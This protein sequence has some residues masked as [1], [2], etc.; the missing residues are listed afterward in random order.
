MLKERIL[1]Q[2]TNLFSIHGIKNVSMDDLASSLGISK[3][4]IYENFKNKEDVLKHCILVAR[5]KRRSMME[6]VISQS[7]NI[8]DGCLHLIHNNKFIRLPASVFWDDIFKYYPE[9][10]QTILEDAAQ[11][12]DYLKELLKKGV[13]DNYFRGNM[14][15]DDS[16]NMLDMSMYVANYGPYPA[17]EL[18]LRSDL[19]SQVLVNM[20]RGISTEKGI[21]IVDKFIADLPHSKN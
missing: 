5:E 2:A 20:I 1:Q 12:N 3:R 11:E 21:E 15:L 7:E 8:V 10:Y 9:I 18:P 4:T 16:A 13:E 6:N 17:R 14:I 19:I